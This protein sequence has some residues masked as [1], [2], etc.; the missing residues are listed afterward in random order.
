MIG[1]RTPGKEASVIDLTMM[2]EIL[3][4]DGHWHK[5]DRGSFKI[6]EYKIGIAEENKIQF[7]G[8]TEKGCVASLMVCWKE[9]GNCMFVP[10][11][12][13]MGYKTGSADG[14]HHRTRA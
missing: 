7:D 5:V 11:T 2:E 1:G 12:S 8:R 6:A 4:G 10:M 9:A 3:L 14:H 13:V